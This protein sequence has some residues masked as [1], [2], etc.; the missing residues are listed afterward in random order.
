MSHLKE[1][2]E[3]NCLNCNAQLHGTYCHICGQENIEPKES[4]WHLVAHFFY[5]ITHFDGKFF[6]TLKYLVSRP[7]FLPAEYGRG[8]RAAYLNPI[9]MYVF[10]SAFFFLIFFS[11]VQTKDNTDGKK[12]VTVSEKLKKLEREKKQQLDDLKSEKDTAEIRG[13]TRLLKL[14]DDDI[15]SLK[16]DSTTN[17]L[18]TDSENFAFIRLWAKKYST[19]QKYDSIQLSLPAEK[20]D[21]YIGRTFKYKIFALNEKYK[22][23][24]EGAFKTFR[25]TFFHSFPQLLF[26]SLPFFALILK[27]LY[28]RRKQFYYVNHLIFTLHFYI[29]AF[30]AMLVYFSLSKL[31]ALSNLGFLDMLGGWIIV[32]IFFYLY[33]A[34]RNFYAQRRA[35]TIIKFL[36]LNFLLLFVQ[37][38][39]LISVTIYS[40]FVL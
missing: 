16:R 32:G 39:L 29:F 17:H 8:R 10:T 21:S 23:N 1:R 14:I 38:F 26:I 33:K 5:D 35:K 37:I 36:L 3:K 2:A 22:H 11:F 40:L 25:E 6:S 4:V 31:A 9:R 13:L 28:V 7:G 18:K 20:R 24:R 15:D 34:M 12:Q 27:L 19:R 30:I